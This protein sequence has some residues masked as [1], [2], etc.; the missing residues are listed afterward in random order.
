MNIIVLTTST[1][2]SGGTRQALYLA[3]GLQKKGFPVYFTCPAACETRKQAESMGLACKP[4]P[5]SFFTAEKSL[6]A[7]MPA[8][9]PC[10][11]HAFH[12]KGVK[13]AAFMGTFWRLKKLPVACVAHRGVTSRPGNPLPY[14]LPGIRAYL[15]NSRAC[16]LTLPLLWRK[17]RCFVVN[18]SVPAERLIPGKP[19]SEMLNRLAVPAGHFVVGDICN[20]NPLKG[21]GRL[22]KAFATA[23]KNLPPSTLLLVG[24]TPERW[25]PLCEEY[26]ILEQVRLI[27][28]TSYVADYLQCMDLLAFPSS[29]IESQP[30]VVVEALCMGVPVIAGAVGG[31]PELLPPEC[32]FDPADEQALWEKLVYFSSEP[33]KRLALGAEGLR[34][35]GEF[36]LEFRLSNILKHYQNCLSEMHLWDDCSD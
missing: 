30:N 29:F 19:K 2:L 3:A 21:V 25:R 18:N 27:P 34:K 33:E 24:V 4:L 15:V 9:K 5:D 14:L 36:S 28:Q 8:D 10:I 23:R 13:W 20:D 7:L 11:V 35:R 32:L 26:G 6:R 1:I 22:I 12:N 16:A 31:V 17:K